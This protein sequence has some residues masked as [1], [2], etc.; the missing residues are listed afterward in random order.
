VFKYVAGSVL[1]SFHEFG[2]HAFKKSM[3]YIIIIIIIIIII[4][5]RR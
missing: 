2:H 4:T 3:K 5:L 1:S